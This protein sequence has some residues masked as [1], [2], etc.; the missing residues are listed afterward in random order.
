VLRLNPGYAD[1]TP[2]QK[3]A[4]AVVVGVG[5]PAVTLYYSSDI[6]ASFLLFAIVYAFQANHIRTVVF[7]EGVIYTAVAIYVVRL[8]S[9]VLKTIEIDS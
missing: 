4:C 5:L 2:W 1:D 9:P 7:M 6:G 8:V 3:V